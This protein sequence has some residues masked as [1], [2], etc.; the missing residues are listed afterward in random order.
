M[1]E[2]CTQKAFQRK[3]FFDHVAPCIYQSTWF[4]TRDEVREWAKADC[5]R[6]GP[7]SGATEQIFMAFVAPRG[8]SVVVKQHVFVARV[9]SVYSK[10]CVCVCLLWFWHP[11]YCQRRYLF[12]RYDDLH[13]EINFMQ[14]SDTF[15]SRVRVVFQL[16]MNSY[17]FIVRTAFSCL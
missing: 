3:Y 17:V 6:H 8:A 16:R 9:F 10:T 1:G 4:R 5:Q 15:A 2:Y 11:S 13:D 7:L 14:R 12:L